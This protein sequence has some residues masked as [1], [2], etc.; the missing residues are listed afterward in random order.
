MEHILP[1]LFFAFTILFVFAI[2]GALIYFSV[3]AVKDSNKKVEF[4]YQEEAEENEEDRYYASTSIALDDPFLKP[5][6]IETVK[7]LFVKEPEMEISGFFPKVEIEEI[8]EDLSQVDE[9]IKAISAQSYAAEK[10][11]FESVVTT[12]ESEEEPE[13]F[14]PEPSIKAVMQMTVSAPAA[15]HQPE[16]QPLHKRIPLAGVAAQA[17]KED[18]DSK[19]IPVGHLSHKPVSADIQATLRG[20]FSN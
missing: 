8:E 14:L 4:V 6:A 17:R 2:C 10:P 12:L 11:Y 7:P 15:A 20:I 16:F 3:K 5:A 1:L 9:F 13:E 18:Q 19:R